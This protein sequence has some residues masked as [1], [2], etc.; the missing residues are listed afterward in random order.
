[1]EPSSPIIFDP[2]QRANQLLQTFSYPSLKSIL[3]HS[4]DRQPLLES[5]ATHPGPEHENLRG[6][7]Y[8]DP[9]NPLV[10]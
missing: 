6:P 5:Q 2:S 7:N 3:K 9:P 10:Q 1:M 8:Y 4:L